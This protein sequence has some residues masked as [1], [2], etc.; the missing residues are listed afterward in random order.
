MASTSLRVQSEVKV[1]S[2]TSKIPGLYIIEPRVFGDARGYFLETFAAERYRQL[3]IVE[4]FVQDNLSRS[5]QGTLRGLH[6]QNP[7]GQGKL[8]SAVVGTVWDV[9]VDVRVGS[10]TFGQWEAFELSE[11]NHRQVYVPPGCAHGF[12]VLSDVALF[13]Y[14][15]TDTYHPET[16]LGVVYDDPD[17]GIAWPI[18][19]S[20]LSERDK[21]HPR[22]KDIDKA[23]LPVFG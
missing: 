1:Q 18:A 4:T 19:A 21:R 2:R 14:K 8:V 3:G 7:H 11:E 13:S 20:E 16:E 12:I 5:R 23:R 10:P 15:C 9:A 17:I 22:L 6:L